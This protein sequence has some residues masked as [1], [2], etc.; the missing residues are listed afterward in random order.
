MMRKSIII[1]VIVASLFLVST[2]SVTAKDYYDAVN[3]VCTD[4]GEDCTHSRPNIDI[5]RLSY[6]Q[7]GQ[8]VELELQ[9]ATGGKITD[10]DYIYYDLFLSTDSNQYTIEYVNGDYAIS[11]QDDNPIDVEAF[12]GAQTNVL[13]VIFN[14]SAGEV[15]DNLSASTLDYSSEDVYY[16]D[17]YPNIEILEV[18]AGGPYSGYT[19]D[20]IQFHGSVVGDDSG[21]TWE[22]DF[23]DKNTSNEQ[24]PTHIYTSTGV[25]DVTLNVYD[26]EGLKG[27][28]DDANVTIRAK[29]SPGGSSNTD[30]KGT[31]N[32]LLPFIVLIVVIVVVG[33]A[34][35]VYVMRR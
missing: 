15:C 21:L 12:S 4:I 32:G 1:G 29:G 23:G 22:W 11:D 2:L 14:L 17:I 6:T 24:N 8:E 26:S 34:V 30:N 31:G 19:G 33:V 20:S 35:V 9:L 10:S 16:T 27:G 18:D 5:Y 3:D 7:T 13:H 28:T 25:Y